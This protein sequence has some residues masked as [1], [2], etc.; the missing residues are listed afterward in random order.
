MRQ[1][2]MVLSCLALA[3]KIGAQEQVSYNLYGTPGLLDM[4]TAQSASDGELAI[5]TS[6]F[7][8]G[9]R[10]T[11]TFQVLP[12]LSGSFRYTSGTLFDRSFDLRYS[13]LS[14]NRYRP[15]IS[16]GLQ[17]VIGTGLFS[18]EYIVATKNYGDVAVTG[19]LGWGRFGSFG[20]FSNPLRVFGDSFEVRPSGFSGTG[21]QLEAT[22][23]FRGDAALFGGVSWRYNNRVTLKAEYSS[24]AYLLETRSNRDFFERKSPLNFGIDY[25]VTEGVQAQA[26]YLYGS[27]FGAAVNFIIDPKQSAVNGGAHGAPIPLQVRET[28]GR[29]LG[30]IDNPREAGSIQPKLNAVLGQDG[31]IVEAVS[32]DATTARVRIRNTKFDANPEAIGRTARVMSVVM[33]AAVETFEI[34]PVVNGVGASQVTLRRSDLEELNH[35]PDASWRSFIRA[36]IEDAPVFSAV[37]SLNEDLYPKLTWS[38]APY[39][40]ASLFDPDSPVR[41]DVGLE[42]AGKYDVAP[43]WMLS[44]AVRQKAAGNLG[45]SPKP[46]NSVIQRVR[47]DSNIYARE[48]TTAV[49]HLTL[50]HHFKP[51]KDL[52][53]RVTAGYLESMYGGIST[54]LLWK[55]VDSRFAVGAELN[56]VK[57]RDFDQLFGFQDYDVVTGH[58]SGYWDMGNGFHGQLDVGR[59]LAGDYG[60]T[61]SL[62]REFANGWKVGA[63]ATFTDV[64]FDDFGE[65]SFDKGLRFTVPLATIMGQPSAQKHTT[66]IQ[67]LLRDGGARLNVEDRLYETIRDYHEPQLRKSWGR[68][69]R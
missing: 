16:V 3:S 25:K 29:D 23:W 27:E 21:G 62:D 6:N 37:E 2:F 20:G 32:F 56:Y 41:L 4:P 13:L 34:I 22:R 30:W 51:G 66:T 7:A 44:G 40:S 12:K 53:G 43:G 42:L 55:P 31:I 5:T 69:W 28:T 9:T 14:E 36:K 48:G 68:F 57:Q 18:G 58:V 11:L 24:D 39:V 33:P 60:A 26:Y 45:G 35:Q 46:S 15:S 8:G 38:L 67:P 10:T 50:A 52:Y 65:G 1:I 64:S 17:D 59:Y 54:E 49:T 63:Y 47:S 61:I 19:G